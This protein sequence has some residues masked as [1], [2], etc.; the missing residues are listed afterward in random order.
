MVLEKLF[1]LATPHPEKNDFIEVWGMNKLKVNFDKEACIEVVL[2]AH[3]FLIFGLWMRIRL[4][5][6][7]QNSKLLRRAL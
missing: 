6:S 5:R 3:L 1:K 7:L 4:K 2:L